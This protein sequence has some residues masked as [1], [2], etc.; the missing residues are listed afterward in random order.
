MTAA[1]RR[2]LGGHIR[3]GVWA[4]LGLVV[5][6]A[7]V[8]YGADEGAAA[9]ATAS[10]GD[11]AILLELVRSGG[12]PAV[13]AAVGWLLGRGG[14]PVRIE[15]SPADRELLE[16]LAAERADRGRRRPREGA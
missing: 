6:L 15:L 16:D 2:L 14:I 12:L 8:A 3:C 5:G 1:A 7:A 11:A 10:T 13:L 4:V 9:P